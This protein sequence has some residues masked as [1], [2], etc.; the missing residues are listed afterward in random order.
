MRCIPMRR[1]K[2]PP[3]RTMPT[4]RKARGPADET[5][6]ARW[7]LRSAYQGDA[8]AEYWLGTLYARG[9]GVPADIAQALHW[10]EAA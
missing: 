3:R 10:Y 7:L 4:N 1:P 6:A 9:A 5:E 2:T 8:V